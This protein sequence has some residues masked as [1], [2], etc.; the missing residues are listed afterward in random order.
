MRDDDLED[1]YQQSKHSWTSSDVLN[2]FQ[3]RNT[4][5]N[6]IAFPHLSMLTVMFSRVERVSNWY[7]W[8]CDARV[9]SDQI[10]EMDATLKAI[11]NYQI[12][13]MQKS[14]ECTWSRLFWSSIHGQLR[15]ETS[16]Q[17]VCKSCARSCEPQGV[18]EMVLAIP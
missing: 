16:S 6:P 4:I 9:R 10:E 18:C 15:D 7:T 2:K 14:I 5:S 3:D 1:L 13:E 17:E 8:L 12:M 11:P